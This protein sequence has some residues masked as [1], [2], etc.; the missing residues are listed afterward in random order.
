M[1]KKI[2]GKGSE[3]K[4]SIKKEKEYKVYTTQYYH[5]GWCYFG[6]GD[7]ILFH[8]KIGHW[9]KFDLNPKSLLNLFECLRSTTWTAHW[10]LQLCLESWTKMVKAGIC[11]QIIKANRIFVKGEA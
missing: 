11:F 6:V 10:R 5:G 1:K 4:E 8:N 2:K 3:R 7:P 9:L